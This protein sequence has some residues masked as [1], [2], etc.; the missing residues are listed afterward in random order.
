[1]THKSRQITQSYK[2]PSKTQFLIQFLYTGT[3][4]S[5][6]EKKSKTTIFKI[7]N[8]RV[9]ISQLKPIF[10]QNWC[11]LHTIHRELI[12]LYFIRC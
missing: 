3:C 9:V 1:M 6:S 12:S 7:T 8:I 10:I 4:S 2:C 5:I 11:I